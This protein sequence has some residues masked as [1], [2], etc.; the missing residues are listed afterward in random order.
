MI[1]RFK[2]L[3][4]SF[5]FVAFASSASLG[6]V[7]TPSLDPAIPAEL[8]SAVAWR[9]GSAFGAKGVYKKEKSETAENEYY[10]NRAGVL[11][12]YQPGYVIGEVYAESTARQAHW[13]SSTDTFTDSTGSSGKLSLA[14]RGEN[15]V[16]VGIGYGSSDQETDTEILSSLFYEGSFSLRLL[17]GFYLAGGIQRVT[18]RLSSGDSRKWNN[19]L[20]GAALQFGDPLSNMLRLEGSFNTSPKVEFNDQPNYPAH[21]ETIVLSAGVEAVYSGFL[22][23]YRYKSTTKNAPT[24]DDDDQAIAEHRL[25]VGFKMEGLTFGLYRDA[26]LE[27]VGDKELNTEEI[28]VTVSYNFI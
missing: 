16:S 8:S 3:L 27:T 12:A 20:A 24:G 23:S 26:G 2:S 13:D 15:R 18:E 10:Y 22:L 19:I 1:I 21:R 28:T 17:G 7:V 4:L 9:F 14:I 6:Q 5:V 25:G 11:F